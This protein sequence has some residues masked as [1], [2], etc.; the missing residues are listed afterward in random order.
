MAYTILGIAGSLRKGS[1]NKMLL[2][3]AK[4]LAG[5]EL[6][7]KIYDIS[8]IPLYNSDEEKE[9]FPDSVKEFKEKI[10]ESDGLIISTPEYNY[11][12]PGVLK[13]AIDWASRPADNSPLNGK[14]L[15]IIGGSAGMSGTI[16][17]QL[18]LRQVALF[19]NMMDMKKPEV[20]VT[21]I[22][23]K[24][25]SD[26]NLID[27]NLRDHLKKFLNSFEKWI[28]FIKGSRQI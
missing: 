10:S 2:N 12:I 22:Q 15:A 27:E 13:N 18:H 7:I 24:F 16:R 5:E 11:S 17:S 23:E 20:L 19:T 28:T 3:T 25:D 1:Y 9:N 21:K 8:S 4:K 14:P 6:N 26:G